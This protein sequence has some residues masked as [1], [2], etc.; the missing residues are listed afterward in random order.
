MK[1]KRKDMCDI[2][3]TWHNDYKVVGNLT[4]CVECMSKGEVCIQEPLDFKWGDVK[5]YGNPKS[6]VRSVK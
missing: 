6:K 5:L 1:H 4:I 3:K 2:C